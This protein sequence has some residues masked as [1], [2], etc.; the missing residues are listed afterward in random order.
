MLDLS[1]CELTSDEK[2]MLDHP[3]VG[4][5]ILFTRN[6]HDMKQLNALVS[7]I[8]LH[9]RNDVIIAVDH[10]GGRVQR[11]RDEFVHIPA[12]GRIY[13][14]TAGDM[15]DASEYAHQFG[16]L[17][18]SELLAHDIDISFAPVLDVK[19]V[20]DVIGDRS[21]GEKPEVI[22]Q[23]ANQFIK[24]MRKAGMR[25][26]GKHFPGHGSVKEDS[27]IAIPVDNRSE[28]EI[29]NYDMRVFAEIHQQG[30]L[31]AVMPAHV[32]YPNVDKLPAGFSKIWI[33]DILRKRLGFDG[34]VFSDDLS[35]QGAAQVGSFAQRAEAALDAGCDMVLVCNDHSAAAEVIDS[36]PTNYS[37]SERLPRMRKQH[38][39]DVES[40]KKTYVYRNALKA[41]EKFR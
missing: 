40:L 23:L 25:S 14:Q 7:Q 6:F 31:D 33:R 18:A 11:F 16:W 12:M 22:I 10:E 4:G 28:S 30:L 5:V 32:I 19:G 3:V 34:V 39:L 29:F 26:T 9:A 36:L 1:S 37:G 21:F 35:M 13:E 17:M 8:R 27:H 2:D 20:S 38:A 24:G 41:V 15:D